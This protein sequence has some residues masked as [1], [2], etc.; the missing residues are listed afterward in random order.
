MNINTKSWFVKF[1]IRRIQKYDRDK[2]WKMRN[3][4][5]NNNNLPTIYKYY[6]LFK[7][8]KIDAF[9]NA[10]FGTDLNTGATFKTIPKLPHGLNGIIIGHDCEIGENVTINHQ[11][12]VMHGNVR[13]GN[14]VILGAGS[15]ILPNVII[16][17]NAKI[18]ANC[19]VIGD[20][21]SGATCVLAKPR[22]LIKKDNTY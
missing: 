3:K 7:L 9:N 13:I 19:V 10:S 18:G 15:K 6:L 2:Y 1:L 17:D 8:K 12:T 16:G 4:I 11:V 20:I 14:N 22:I 21:P 5:V